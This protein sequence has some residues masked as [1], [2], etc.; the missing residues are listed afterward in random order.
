[1]RKVPRNTHKR[2]LLKCSLTTGSKETR[3]GH[4]A[5]ILKIA[6]T[7]SSGVALMLLSIIVWLGG[8]FTY[9]F[10]LAVTAQIL[11]FLFVIVIH[12]YYAPR[13]IETTDFPLKYKDNARSRGEILQSYFGGKTDLNAVRVKIVSHDTTLIDQV[14]VILNQHGYEI[15][16]THDTFAMFSTALTQPDDWSVMIFDLDLFNNLESSIDELVTFRRRWP[17]IPVLLVSR[18]ASGDEL[19]GHRRAIG[20]ATLRKPVSEDRLIKGLEAMF[21]NWEER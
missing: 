19:S 20:D 5:P 13:D 8:T 2:K 4:I 12:M 6:L 18:S 16:C 21:L 10:L 9:A 15:C 17:E 3:N 1:M 7:L 11:I 14:K